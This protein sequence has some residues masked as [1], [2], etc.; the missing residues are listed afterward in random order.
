LRFL[1]LDFLS[2]LKVR[3]LTIVDR[4]FLWQVRWCGKIIEEWG[5]S[6]CN[7]SYDGSGRG[8]RLGIASGGD[9]GLSALSL[10]EII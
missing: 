7:L 6:V 1:L 4:G 8:S 10:G 2:P 5:F 9:F 3:A